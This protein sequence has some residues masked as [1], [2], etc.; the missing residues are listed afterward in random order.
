L[1]GR[2]L[3]TGASG[4][5]GRHLLE[6]LIKRGFTVVAPTRTAQPPRAGVDFP[7]IDAI[8][9]A[10]WRPLLAG[11]DAVVHLAAIAHTRDRASDAYDRT[12]A[13]AT[14][15][16]ART[17]AGRVPRFIFASSIRAISGPTTDE[18]LDDNSPARPTDAYGRSKLKAENGLAVL[19][20][21]TTILRPVVAY[22]RGVKGNLEKLAR[23]ADSSLPLPFGA[24]RASRSFLS[25]DNL[26]SAILFALS[27]T[28]RGTES[29]V[30]A[31][32]EPSS[33]AELVSGLR[34]GLDRPLRLMNVSPP[35]LGAAAQILGQ[36]QNWAL[37]SGPLAVRPR[38]LIEAGWS[39][40]VASSREGARLWGENLRRR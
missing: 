37:L 40:P 32:P 13:E 29:F 15:R 4:F 1:S 19:D 21:P 25:V 17:C 3:V 34:L 8:E 30:L 38:K 36:A 26:V 16:L 9:T 11:V 39:A 33:V 23:L 2:I 6:A 7:A 24:L 20:L 28:A 22:G 35:L 31:D 5:V 10:D 12:N 14:L 18:I 27:R